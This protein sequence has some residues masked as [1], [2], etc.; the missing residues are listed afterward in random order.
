M[1]KYG[2]APETLQ[3]ESQ[4]LLNHVQLVPK[5]SV[6]PRPPPSQFKANFKSLDWKKSSGRSNMTPAPRDESIIVRYVFCSHFFEGA[7][8]LGRKQIIAL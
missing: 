5:D 6:D 8:C 7:F 2:F 4:S 3:A 1:K